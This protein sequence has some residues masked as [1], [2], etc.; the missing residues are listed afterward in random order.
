M[1]HSDNLLPASTPLSNALL[2][3]IKLLSNENSDDSFSSTSPTHKL[4]PEPE[5]VDMDAEEEEDLITDSVLLSQMSVHILFGDNPQEDCAFSLI[6]NQHI[7]CSS[8]SHKY[9]Y[10]PRVPG[11]LV[12]HYQIKHAQ[13]DFNPDFIVRCHCGQA[14]P[15]SQMPLHL[16]THPAPPPITP[17]EV[18][19]LNA[20][21]VVQEDIGY[22]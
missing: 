15:N 10:P 16:T 19:N 1:A 4:Q 9:M 11:V 18:R 14:I 13:P 7:Q 8:C 20:L 6:D 5:Y 21:P 17:A 22:E 12:N 2:D 3:R